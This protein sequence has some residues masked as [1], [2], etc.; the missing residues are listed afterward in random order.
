MGAGDYWIRF[1]RF[2]RTLA[3]PSTTG[4]K[5]NSFTSSGHLWGRW[6][7]EPE[8]YPIDKLRSQ[9][10]ETRGTIAFRNYI[11]LTLRDKLVTAA[12]VE[13]EIE[14]WHYGDNETLCVVIQLP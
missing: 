14:T 13:W 6:V 3:N 5:V 9:T 4:E 1:E 11:D 12:G 7:I 10:Q 2:A 8:A